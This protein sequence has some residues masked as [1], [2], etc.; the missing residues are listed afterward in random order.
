MG[1]TYLSNLVCASH[2]RYEIWPE[3]SIL[4]VNRKKVGG[5]EDPQF[6]GSGQRDE[7]FIVSL[8]LLA[9]EGTGQ[10]E[11]PLQRNKLLQSLDCVCV[12]ACVCVLGWHL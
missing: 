2:F 10:G 11:S 5:G 7:I 9:T 6:R 1:L 12:S 8:S 3:E 4:S